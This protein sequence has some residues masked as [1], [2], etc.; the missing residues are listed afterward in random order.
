MTGLSRWGWRGR[1]P[2]KLSGLF[3]DDCPQRL[4]RTHRQ[5]GTPVSQDSPLAAKI[6]ERTSASSLIVSLYAFRRPATIAGRVRPVVID[7]IQRMLYRWPRSHVASKCNKTLSPLIAHSYPARTVISIVWVALV[8]ATSFR[9]SPC[10]IFNGPR[11]AVGS[12]QRTEAFSL[13]APT[14]CGV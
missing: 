4:V 10:G 12:C 8:V 3:A 7:A 6:D 13:V 2:M 5:N 14:A 11:P 9:S 1:H